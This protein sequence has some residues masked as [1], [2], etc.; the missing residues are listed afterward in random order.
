MDLSVVIPTYNQAELLAECLRSLMNQTLPAA[1]Y[2]I[3]VVDD[4][5]TDQT[6]IVLNQYAK[7]QPP[8]AVIR[9]PSNR[10][11]SAARNAGIARASASLVVFVDSDVIVRSDFLQWHWQTH[12]QHGPGILS[13]GPVVLT[14]D[15]RM[16]MEGPVPRILTSPAYLDTA[17]AAIPQTALLQA[18]LFD[19]AFPGYGWEDFELGL[20]LQRLGIRRVFC[21]QAVAFHVQPPTQVDNVA[22]LLQKEEERAKS[23]VYFYH[24]HPTLKTKILIQA[25]AFHRA[26]YWLQAAGGILSPRNISAITN[27]M[28]QKGLHSLAFLGL[29][30]VLNLHYIRR[31][32]VEFQRDGAAL[33]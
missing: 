33:N 18:G 23:A 30:G 16:A 27:T 22:S 10:G 9:F 15:V 3:I 4:G 1:A 12:R 28:R 31:L 20:R 11:R 25:T 29:R 8:L 5:S 6:Q 26:L 7:N 24:K 2:E 14:S 13:R 32:A 21:R 17:N 19:E